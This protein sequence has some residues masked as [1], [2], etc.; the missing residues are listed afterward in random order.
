QRPTLE[1]PHLPDFYKYTLFNEL[2]FMTDGGTVWLDSTDGAPNGHSEVESAAA[3]RLEALEPTAAQAAA[4]AACDG[5]QGTIGQFLYL[6]GHEYAMYNTYDV[7]F[8][9]SFAM[10]M[11]WPMLQLSLQRDIALSVRRRDNCK[12]TLLGEGDHRPRKV[13]GIVPHDL[14]SPAEEPYAKVNAYVF[15]DVSRWKDLGPKFVLQVYRD[16]VASGSRVFLQD[17]WPDVQ[18]VMKFTEAWDTD[19]D[20]LIENQ[21]FPDQTFDIWTVEGPS[22]YTGGLWVAAVSAT[23][24]MAEILRDAKVLAYYSDLLKRGKQAYVDKLWNGSYFNYDSS[25]SRHSNSVMADQMAGQWYARACG[26]EPVVDEALAR[27]SLRAVYEHNVQRF[28]NGLLG[29]VNGMRPNGGVDNT[30]L[31][32]REVWTGVTYACGAAMLHEASVALEGH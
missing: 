4:D 26:L 10:A 9:A 32:S 8:Y 27:S 24:R 3:G 22:A 23:K 31:Q 28:G 19:G 15:Q 5:R 16:F 13:F 6:E 18:H 7:H 29:A 20:G 12:R 30:C 2:Y 25:G 1:D 17:M 11:L 14:G 21:G